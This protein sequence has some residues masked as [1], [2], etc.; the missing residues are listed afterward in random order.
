MS[1]PVVKPTSE[2]EQEQE[3]EQGE[4]PRAEQVLPLDAGFDP[5]LVQRTG[6]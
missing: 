5:K 2:Q 1:K 6:L 4:E 3:L